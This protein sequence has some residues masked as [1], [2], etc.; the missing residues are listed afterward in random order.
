MVGPNSNCRCW[1]QSPCA[2]PLLMPSLCQKCQEC[3]QEISDQREATSK[4][5]RICGQTRW[6]VS[7]NTVKLYIITKRS[8][9]HSALIKILVYKWSNG[10]PTIILVVGGARNIKLPQNSGADSSKFP[11]LC[12]YTKTNKKTNPEM[13]RT[14][15]VKTLE[16][17]QKSTATKWILNQRKGSF[18]MVGKLCGIF[19]CPCRTS[20]LTW[21]QSWR[22]QPVFQYGTLVLDSRGSRVDLI[23]RLLC[24]SVLSHLWASWR[25]ESRHLCLFA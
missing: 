25:T 7:P 16:N 12:R 18:K 19:A 1:L 23:Y 21:W 9:M 10:T 3:R 22:Q 17:G 6:G 24:L 11:F 14:N 8:L 13:L 4:A 5:D 20:S 2:Y 15:T